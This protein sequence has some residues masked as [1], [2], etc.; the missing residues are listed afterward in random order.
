MK[1]SISIFVL[2]LAAFLSV[3]TSAQTKHDILKAK[4]TG[5]WVSDKIPLT[6]DGLSGFM[7]PVLAFKNDQSGSYSFKITAKINL[8]DYST[9][10]IEVTMAGNAPMKWTLDESNILHVYIDREKFHMNISEKCFKV[11]NNDP[12]AKEYLESNKNELINMLYNFKDKM[13]DI[14]PETASWSDISI[15]GAR[16]KMTDNDG[17]E[18][19]LT[20]GYSK[21]HTKNKSGKKTQRKHA[22]NK[23]S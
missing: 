15:K 11:N 20:R 17:V 21:S 7:T 23:Q 8:D 13:V 14:L 22:N 1:K 16:L 4:L 12:V 19:S 6:D 2:L 5:T 3:N 18:V 10:Y 9:S